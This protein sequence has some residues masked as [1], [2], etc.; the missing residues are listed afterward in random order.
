MSIVRTSLLTIAFLTSLPAATPLHHSLYFEERGRG[1][2]ESRSVAIR[3][4]RIELDGITLHFVNASDKARMEG[5]GPE[6]PATYLTRGL[7]RTFRQ[8]PKAA[9]RGLYPGI[10]A[11]FYG[12]AGSLEYDLELAPG[13]AT[14]QIR[15]EVTGARSLRLDEA[16]NLIA[17]T[18]SGQL[19]QFAPRVFQTDRGSRRQIAAKYTLSASALSG[20]GLIGFEFE[21]YDRTIPLTI[22][23]VVVYT[24]YIGGS[25]LDYGGPVATDTQGNVYLTGR[26]S[27][28]D[29]PSTNGTSSRLQPP[30]L[31][32]SNGGQTVTPLQVGTQTSV[33]AIAGTSDGTVLYVATPDGIFI[34]TNHGASFSQ[35]APLSPAGT[36]NAIAVD[37]I[38]PSRA[39]IATTTGLFVMT[40]NGQ[41]TG[42][43]DTGMAVSGNGNVNAASVQISAVD[44]AVIYATTAAPNYLYKSSDASATWTQLNPAYPGEPPPYPGTSLTFTLT[45]SGSVL[46]VVDGNGFLLRSSDGGATWQQL[47]SQLFG[48][49]SITIDPNNSANIFVVDNYGVQQSTNGGV[50]FTTV[51]PPLPGGTNVRSFALDPSTGNL[52]FSTYNQIE[53]SADHGATWKVLPPR[54]D[55]QVLLG[56]GSQVFAGVYSPAIPFIT[57]W[58]ADGSTLLFSTF[59][60]GSYA[61]SIT[62]IA[63]DAQGD[64]IIAGSTASADFPVTKTISPAS[65][66][67]SA[68][69]FV[70]KLSADGTRAIYSSAIGASQGLSINGL[71]IDAAGAPYITGTTAS[72]D[73]PT[74]A[75]VFQPTS[76]AAPCQRPGASPFLPTP[77]LGAHAFVSKLSADGNTLLYST[78]LTGSCGSSGQGIAVDA[79]DEAVVVGGT[80]SADFPVSAGAYQS[81]FPGGAAASLAYPSTLDMG[82]V[83]K[84]SAA[85]D[86]AIA[87]SLIG[88]GYATQAN[89]LGLDSSGNAY[90]TG[91]TWGITPGSTPGVYQNKVNA[92]CP[93]VINI[94]PGNNQPS[95]GSDAF[96]LKLNATLSSAQYLTYLG[97]ICD[98][99]GTSLALEP[100]GNV[101]IAGNPSQS[102]PLVS[103]FE[104]AGNFVSEFSAD[105]SQLLFSSYS[106]GGWLALDPSGSVYVSGT[107][108]YAPGIHKTTG[109]PLGNS[110]SLVKINP[111]SNPPVIV[112]SIGPQPNAAPVQFQSGIVVAPGE[113][114]NITGQNLGPANGLAAQLDATGQLPFLVGTTSVLF[115][116]YYAPLLSVQSGLI[117]CAAPFEIRGS[118]VVTIK[119]GGQSSNSV[120]IGVAATAPYIISS[121]NQDGTLNSTSRPAPKGSV[122]TFYVTGLGLTSPLS[123]D[124]S[125]SAPPLP[126]PVAPVLVFIGSNQVQPQFAGAADE[127]IAGITQVNVQMPVATYPS[128]PVSAY[129][130][131]ALTQLYIA[132]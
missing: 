62:A 94:G 89:A 85:G 119:V 38:D 77:N 80:T 20:S 66:A 16:G 51:S 33:T 110:A 79:A 90:I 27:S 107:S 54:P 128:N 14:D 21:Q 103:P 19:R 24:K 44:H 39:F 97:G 45:P 46:Y 105:A 6:A 69:G 72:P 65:A 82:F 129:I 95:G 29:F 12:S 3:S 36:V 61:D 116:G 59:F 132:Q 37:A 5:I 34:S 55:P 35:G 108:V 31:A 87:S 40:S 123:Q 23:P 114:L 71:T 86:K 99:S 98:D 118:T 13:A 93:P 75:N 7:T 43:N 131:G 84:L 111:V 122:M 50:S 25:D 74:T 1:L 91:S 4:D 15:I 68:G 10:D 88:G 64:A 52:Y 49:K 101:W 22:D 96:L 81:T 32:F 70:A 127:A 121:V 8:Y 60:G 53:V 57:K 112:S 106:D 109:Y 11:I 100:N 78:F 92:G 102:F 42:R 56:L 17:D 117:V 73:F 28:V 126:V 30:L 18:P 113:L 125:V 9:I 115:D 130:G 124:G 26:T 104:T 41:I 63:V 2:F 48:A 67:G 76:P 58:S 120:R 83:T 47:A